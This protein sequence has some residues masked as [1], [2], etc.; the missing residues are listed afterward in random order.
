MKSTYYFISVLL[1][2]LLFVSC[3]NKQDRKIES[4]LAFAGENRAELEHALEYY[5]YTNPDKEKLDAVKFLIENMGL[6]RSLVPSVKL[7]FPYIDAYIEKADSLLYSHITNTHPD[8][9][10]NVSTKKR[11]N[12]I[13]EEFKKTNPL[14]VIDSIA[15]YEMINVADCQVITSDFLINHVDLMFEVRAKNS[16][17]LQDKSIFYEYVL[18]YKTMPTYAMI[19]SSTN[20]YDL[21][22]KY[23]ADIPVDSIE[24]TVKRYNFI[25]REFK[26]LIKPNPYRR[27]FGIQELFFSGY[28][29]CVRIADFGAHILRSRGLPIAVEQLSGYRHFTNNHFI[30]SIQET[31]GRWLTFAPEAF[32]PRYMDPELCNSMNIYRFMYSEQTDSPFFLKGKDEYVPEYL[33]SPFIKD[34]SK[35]DI[36]TISLDIPFDKDTDNKLAYLAVFNRGK[37]NAMHPVT[38]GKIKGHKV[39]FDNVIP[40][41]MYFPIYYDNNGNM[42]PFNNPF[43][44]ST[45]GQISYPDETKMQNTVKDFIDIVVTSKYPRRLKEVNNTEGLIGS[46]ILGSNNPSFENADTLATI[47]SLLRPSYQDLQLDITRGPYQY[48]KFSTTESHPSAYIG[49]I[50]FLTSKNYKYKNTIEPSPLPILK[51]Q[52]IFVDSEAENNLVKVLGIPQENGKK[53]S[54][55]DGNPQTGPRNSASF[56]FSLD[57]P[58]FINTARLMPIHAD[59][60]VN[61]GD[62]YQIFYYERGKWVFHETI[63][64]EYNHIQT[65]VPKGRLYWLRNTTKGQEELPFFIDDNGEQKF[66]YMMF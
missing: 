65:R 61:I 1:I 42:I 23:F 7:S 40:D 50:E 25:I 38:W 44:V 58:M 48:Y 8:S 20:Y 39:K 13:K 27:F 57:K 10:Y 18:P 46:V 47:K 24:L 19:N 64:A 34:A 15:K 17:K 60:G 35:Y 59:N 51:P 63:T 26:N 56:L 43:Y 4:V 41:R 52:D 11:F 49:E 31:E 32:L 28:M 30:C 36:P 9:L 12:A 53:K 6:H 2:S 14:P 54:E 21:F 45:E 37:R 5:K 55:S 66:I 33:L 16:K 3:K 22:N 62:T 29:D